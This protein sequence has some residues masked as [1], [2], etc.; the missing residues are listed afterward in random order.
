M[1]N[2]SL[3]LAPAGSYLDGTFFYSLDGA[4]Y[5]GDFSKE[6]ML[7]L[8]G[9]QFQSNQVTIEFNAQNLQGG[10]RDID[11]QARA[12]IPNSC[13][14]IYEVLPDGAAAW[15]PVT[16]DP[17]NPQPPFATAPVLMRFRGRFVGSPDIMPGII[18]PDS[19]MKI[20]APGPTFTFVSVVETLAIPS[21]NISVKIRVENFNPTPHSISGSTGDGTGSIRIFY[22]GSYKNPTS[23]SLNLVD[24]SRGIYDVTATFGSVPS[25]SAFTICVKGTTNSI[26]DVY[27]VAQMVWWAL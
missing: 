24:L 13:Q 6:M 5:L 16:V 7:E 19:L 20:W 25:T 9:A 26:T 21:T 12:L 17:T 8:W 3:G 23:V 10:I 15:L 14:L 27:L 4:Y 18:L 1:G 11:L 22:G 2:H